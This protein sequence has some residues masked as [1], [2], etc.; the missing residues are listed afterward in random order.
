MIDD[1]HRKDHDARLQLMR[2]S[3][4]TIL[5]L[6]DEAARDAVALADGDA[7]IRFIDA[8]TA[9]RVDQ[10]WVYGFPELTSAQRG[11]IATAPANQQPRM[12]P[13]WLFGIVPATG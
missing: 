13:N 12:L 9:H 1:A 10:S 7:S 8:S 2:E 6:P 4:I 11:M 3:D 5:C